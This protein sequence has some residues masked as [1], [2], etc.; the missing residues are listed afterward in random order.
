MGA[1]LLEHAPLLAGLIAGGIAILVI[2]LLTLKGRVKGM[3]KKRIAEGKPVL[4]EEER[5]LV[6]GARRA[7][8][9]ETVIIYMLAAVLGLVL[10]HFM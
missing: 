6:T 1:F 4:T 8:M 10:S 2:Q 5:E 7:E 9:I 3:D